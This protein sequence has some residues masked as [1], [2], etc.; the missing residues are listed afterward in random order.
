M[1]IQGLCWCIDGTS[2]KITRGSLTHLYRIF[3]FILSTFNE[4]LWAPWETCCGINSIHQQRIS[5]MSTLMC[6][7]PL[8]WTVLLGAHWAV[9]SFPGSF[10]CVF[11]EDKWKSPSCPMKPG[12]L[13]VNN[14]W[15]IN[16]DLNCLNCWPFVHE[17]GRQFPFVHYLMKSITDL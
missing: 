5:L 2:K 3:I 12:L 15:D 9:T 8:W 1:L 13:R 14:N 6:S 4:E 16:K 17:L 11:W 7:V 10:G